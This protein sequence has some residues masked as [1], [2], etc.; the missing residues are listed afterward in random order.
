[1]PTTEQF[2]TQKQ[3]SDS[4]DI[5]GWLLARDRIGRH[6][7]PY[8]P[9]AT[10]DHHVSGQQ[11]SYM[12]PPPTYKITQRFSP[13]D[14]NRTPTPV[15]YVPS[16]PTSYFSPTSPLPLHTTEEDSGFESLVTN[17]SDSGS[18]S[19]HLVAISPAQ[20]DQPAVHLPTFSET[21]YE[22]FST[23]Y[24]HGIA[25][26]PFPTRQLNNPVLNVQRNFYR[27]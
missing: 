8:R 4:H 16:I 3:K 6:P 11:Q 24:Q 15:Q 13:C 20:R 25:S 21:P 27:E 14:L 1:M 5:Q 26:A 18:L 19:S 17:V 23:I 9:I 22:N 2:W 7:S 12:T 10:N